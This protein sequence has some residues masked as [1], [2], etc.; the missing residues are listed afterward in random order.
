MKGFLTQVERIKKI[1]R[2]G[3]ANSNINSNITT[4]RGTKVNK[5]DVIEKKRFKN[6]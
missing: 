3:G 2:S 6:I 4:D 5:K 1:E